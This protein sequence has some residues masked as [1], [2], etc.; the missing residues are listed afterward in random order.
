[1]TLEQFLAKPEYMSIEQW[2]KQLARNKKADK[3]LKKLTEQRD[4]CYDALEVLADEKGSDRWQR[5]S[6]K[7]VETLT[8]IAKIVGDQ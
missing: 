7:L 2:E 5:W 3:R 8:E 1:M 6:D 4:Q